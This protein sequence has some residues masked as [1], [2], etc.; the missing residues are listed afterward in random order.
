LAEEHRTDVWL[1]EGVTV[2]VETDLKRTLRQG[3]LREGEL[4]QLERQLQGALGVL[5]A[6]GLVHSDIR[7][8]N[9]LLVD[10][11][12]RLADLGGVVECGAPIVALQKDAE[13]VRPG[14][15]IGSPAEPE[16]D[17]FALRVVLRHAAQP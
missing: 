11:K 4:R 16:N 15:P 9:I 13:Y 17:I 12:W 7:Q 14:V 6:L 3:P 5:H 2:R 1:A 8:D 10:G